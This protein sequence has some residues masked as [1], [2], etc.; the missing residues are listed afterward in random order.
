MQGLETHF[1][2]VELLLTWAVRNAAEDAD[3]SATVSHINLAHLHK[4][5][6]KPSSAMWT[7]VNTVVEGNALDYNPQRTT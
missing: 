1:L 5:N 6:G 3:M 4:N 2:K 7:E